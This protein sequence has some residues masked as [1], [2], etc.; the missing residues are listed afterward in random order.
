M[1]RVCPCT[2][3]WRDP[4]NLRDQHDALQFFNSLVDSLDE[5]LKALGQVSILE[6]VLGGSLADQKICKDCP[7][8]YCVALSQ[9]EVFYEIDGFVSL[10]VY[11]KH[12]FN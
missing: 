11:F 8:R 12:T 4:V 3:L 2:R 5:S 9:C 7:H 10:F 1:V 6:K